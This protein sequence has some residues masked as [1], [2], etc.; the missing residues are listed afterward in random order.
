VLQEAGCPWLAL[1]DVWEPQPGM[2]KGEEDFPMDQYGWVVACFLVFS[3]NES[4]EQMSLFK[5]ICFAYSLN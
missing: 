1:M 3:F 5:Y 4:S 2:L